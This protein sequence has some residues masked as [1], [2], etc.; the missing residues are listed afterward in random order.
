VD[1]IEQ[2]TEDIQQRVEILG[3]QADSLQAAVAS[4]G[5]K[6]SGVRTDFQALTLRVNAQEDLHAQRHKQLLAA[7]G[8]VQVEIARVWKKAEHAS[9]DAREARAS[10]P[11]DGRLSDIAV[12]MFETQVEHATVEVERKRESIFARRERHMA[13]IKWGTAAVLWLFTSGGAV[14]AIQTCGG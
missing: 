14:L 2:R 12:K 3:A 5:L 11:D 7:M 9:D 6:L 10:R 13:L 1:G 8:D 4:L